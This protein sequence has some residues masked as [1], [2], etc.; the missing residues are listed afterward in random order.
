M[1]N[2]L[3]TILV[4]LVVSPEHT[5]ACGF[6]LLGEEYRI[7][8]LNPYLLGDDYSAF[9]YSSEY[10]HKMENYSKGAD[11]RANVSAWAQELGNGVTADD[12]FAIIYQAGLEEWVDAAAGNVPATFK[13]NPA[14]IAVSKRPAIQEYL[15]W[16]KAY[17]KPGFYDPWADE[18]DDQGKFGGYRQ[19]F[20]I[21]AQE[22]YK[23]AASNNFLR[24]RWAYQLLLLARYDDR[25]DDVRRLHREHFAGKDGPLAVWASFQAAPAWTDEGK[26][27]IAYANAFAYA[28]E[29]AFA[30][31]NRSLKN[32]DPENYNDAVHSNEESANLYV[33]Q[34]VKNPGPAL[35]AIQNAYELAPDH[36]LIELL[37]VREINK[38]EDWLMTNQLTNNEPPVQLYEDPNFDTFEQYQADRERLRK[39]AHK[40]DLNYLK[41]LR[42]F[43]SEYEARPGRKDFIRLLRAHTALM[44]DD[45][46]R[47][48]LYSNGLDQGDTPLADQARIIRYL[49]S[50][51]SGEVNNQRQNEY[52][53][54]TLPRLM[55]QF[56]V[57]SAD[58]YWEEGYVS[59]YGNAG[60]AL[61]RIT[62]QYYAAQGD[63]ATA[64]FLHNLSSDLAYNS[65][66]ASE[67]YTDIDYLDRTISP[68][69]SDKII[70]VL[71]GKHD[72]E[73][74][75]A[76]LRRTARVHANAVRDVA[77][78]VALRRNDPEQAARYFSAI[79][80]SWYA[81]AYEF[82]A[83]LDQSP[84]S[85]PGNSPQVFPGKLAVAK[86]LAELKTL[87]DT[88]D[89]EACKMLGTAWANMSYYGNTWMMLSYGQSS[90]SPNIVKPW[91]MIQYSN[92]HS[93][94]PHEESLFDLIFLY[95]R[96]LHYLECGAAGTKD[97]EERAAI[98]FTILELKISRASYQ[99]DNEPFSDYEK[100]NAAKAAAQGRLRKQYA[101]AYRGTACF[102]RVQMSCNSLTGL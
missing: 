6:Y 83:Y 9:F 68:A 15:L 10:L 28:P 24:Q 16:A 94:Y 56:P 42:S 8:L 76:F 69:V 62:S 17:E 20:L 58:Y 96:A 19:N 98:E 31:Y 5:K 53:A 30:A 88:G 33:L 54:A 35:L 45:F 87:A 90:S 32:F 44:D 51:Q 101:D 102:E 86:R 100:T 71:S 73:P 27:L 47:A 97:V 22:G 23:K 74:L 34:A 36:H 40:G 82:S 95:E 72:D 60:L 48:M 84:F 13:S 50:I 49:A 21:R 70:A 11:R 80:A 61:P 12:A 29:K 75:Y 99:L 67:Y 3:L 4:L 66:W 46:Y 41:R 59:I 14:W 26:Q 79:P 91:P 7:A 85:L 81:G 52:V 18:P 92:T 25:W 57:S 37:L 39:K 55:K 2:F 64:F 78:T 89:A 43:L 65:G 93:A 77:G 1:R 63:T 38:L